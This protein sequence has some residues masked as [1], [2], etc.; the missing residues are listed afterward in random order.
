MSSSHC[1]IRMSRPD[2]ALALHAYYEQIAAEGPPWFPAPPE[3]PSV[4]NTRDFIE[5]NVVSGKHGQFLA[6][7]GTAVL[8]VLDVAPTPHDWYRHT[9]RVTISVL[10][11][12]RRKGLGTLLGEAA[13]QWAGQNQDIWR[14]EM[15]VLEPNQASLALVDHFD[16]K[17]EAVKEF[18]AS[19]PSGPVNTILFSRV[20]PEKAA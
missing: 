18:A 6:L 20:W 15:E 8:G 13:L 4:E 9:Y 1:E 19:A 10:P 16:F 5:R 2:D 11:S 7:Q 3:I 14:V 17:L 12:S